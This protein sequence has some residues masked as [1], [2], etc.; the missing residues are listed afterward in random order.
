MTRKILSGLTVALI[1]MQMSGNIT[2]QCKGFARKSCVSQ[3]SPYLHDG[4][5]DAAMLTEGEEADIYK[6]FYAGQ[7]YRIVVCNSD[8]LPPVEFWVIDSNRQILFYNKEHGMCRNWD[9]VPESS[10]QVKILIKV[11]ANSNKKSDDEIK[12]GCVAILVGLKGK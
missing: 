10:K 12:N 5:F 3:L 4:S 11:P 1:F 6:T 9:F 8:N 2:A 7:Q